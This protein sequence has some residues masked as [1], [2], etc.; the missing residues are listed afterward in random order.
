WEPIA[1]LNGAGTTDTPQ[2]YRFEDADLPYAADSLS[3]RLRQI[4]TGGT[5]SFSEAVTIARQVTEAEL[6]PTYPNPARSQATVRF[7]V[8]ERQDV[9]I[10]LYDM[11]GRRI[12]TVVDTNAEGRTE[13]QLDVSGLASGTYFLQMQTAG[14]T[15]TER[16]TVV[17]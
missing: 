7:A 12:R 1:R 10:T 6:L 4:D 17:R 16:I 13:A 5:E 2:S 14:Y 11:L 9:R 15:D 8:P 3:Y